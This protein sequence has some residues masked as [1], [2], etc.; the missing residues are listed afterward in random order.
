MI[1]QSGSLGKAEAAFQDM[2]DFVKN[3]ANAEELRID[4]VERE[5]FHRL[6]DAGLHLLGA[7]AAGAK[8]RSWQNRRARWKNIGS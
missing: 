5:L 2:I 3:A 7:F 4:E 6:L 8:W 1:T